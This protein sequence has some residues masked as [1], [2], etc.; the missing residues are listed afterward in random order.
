[1]TA[2][3]PL[4]NS[5]PPIISNK[6]RI[7]ILG[8]MP[9]VA[10]LE[11]QQY[12]AHPRNAFWPIMAELFSFDADTAYKER[13][14]YL[15]DYGVA[16]WD[17]LKACSRPG[18][19]D[20]HIAPDSMQSNNLAGMFASHSDIRTVFFNGGKAEQVFRRLILPDL[21]DTEALRLIRLPST[22]PANASLSFQQKL[23]AWRQIK[24]YLSVA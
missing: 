4:R 5:F 13:C 2:N 20:Q 22:S 12:Y 3:T 14:E 1:M 15:M 11:A 19:L 16:V 10:S 24:D 7:L 21:S 6:A 23:A 9:G 17:V 8:S 18:S